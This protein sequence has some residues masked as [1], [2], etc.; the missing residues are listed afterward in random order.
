MMQ[1]VVLRNLLSAGDGEARGMGLFASC[2]IAWPRPTI[3]FRPYLAP[4]KGAPAM[5]SLHARLRQL[6][7]TPQAARTYV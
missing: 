1:P 2:L 3:G 5:A 7:E 6:L 4:A